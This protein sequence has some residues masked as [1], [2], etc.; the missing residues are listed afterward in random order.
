MHRLLRIAILRSNRVAAILVLA[1]SLLSLS[2]CQTTRVEQR[3]LG[4]AISHSV[5]VCEL[6]KDISTYSDRRVEVRGVYY[7]G[8]RARERSEGIL[9]GGRVWPL[10][11][12]LAESNSVLSEDVQVPFITDNASWSHLNDV[13]TRAGLAGKKVEILVTISGLIKGPQSHWVPNSG[14][15]RGYGHLGAYPAQLIVERVRNVEI[16]ET[17]T[18]DY[19]KMLPQKLRR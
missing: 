14:I 15:T 3:D 11:L 1:L 5:T 9:A 10:A 19:S 16:D 7:F 12:D 13:A 17:P 8:L 4:Q 6:F 18:Y 2:A